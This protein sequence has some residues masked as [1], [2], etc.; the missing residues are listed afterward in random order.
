MKDELGCKV[1]A[2]FAALR[3]KTHIYFA[4]HSAKNRKAKKV[5]HKTKT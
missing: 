1:M 5:C 4:N 3:A 2:E